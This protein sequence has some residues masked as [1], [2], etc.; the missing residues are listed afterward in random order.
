MNGLSLVSGKRVVLHAAYTTFFLNSVMSFVLMSQANGQ[1]FLGVGGNGDFFLS[2]VVF[3]CEIACFF[4]CTMLKIPS[5]ERE[6]ST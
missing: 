6:R 1:L 4:F 3:H 5:T 2:V